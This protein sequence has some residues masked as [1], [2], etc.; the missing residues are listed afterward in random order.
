MNREASVVS[1]IFNYY[2]KEAL[3]GTLE[4]VCYRL[5]PRIGDARVF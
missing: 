5:H 2:A 3:K 1:V 4:E